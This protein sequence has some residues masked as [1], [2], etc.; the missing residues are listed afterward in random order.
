[1]GEANPAGLSLLA[2]IFGSDPVYGQTSDGQQCLLLGD[3]V[4]VARGF[5][6]WGD[7]TVWQHNE[8]L[9]SVTWG[10]V[11]ARFSRDSE[12]T[13]AVEAHEHPFAGLARWVR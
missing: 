12:G 10:G 13:W 11:S 2:E 3:H 4:L 8:G 1:M 5:A 6:L 9:L 7:P